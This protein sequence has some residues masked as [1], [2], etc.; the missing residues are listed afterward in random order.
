MTGSPEAPVFSIEVREEQYYL[1]RSVDLRA[2]DQSSLLNYFVP[3]DWLLSANGWL[4][5]EDLTNQMASPAVRAALEFKGVLTTALKG[6]YGRP[7]LVECLRQTDWIDPQGMVG[8]RRDVF[9]KVDD[10]PCVAASTL[11]PANVIERYPWLANLGN[12]PLGEMLENHARY[13]R[14]AF[15]FTQVDANPI[16]RLMNGTVQYTWARRCRFSLDVGDLR[17]MEAFLPGLLDRIKPE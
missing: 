17:V 3:L 10:R 4:S 15:E 7:V 16:F 11:M 9:L 14:G 8:L 5:S 2:L 6:V 12:R 13:R 1:I